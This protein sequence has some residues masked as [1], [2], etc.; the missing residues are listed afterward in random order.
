MKS[1]FSDNE[2]VLNIFDSFWCSCLKKL[3]F[4]WT[5]LSCRNIPNVVLEENL[6]TSTSPGVRKSRMNIRASGGNKAYTIWWDKFSSLIILQKVLYKGFR[7]CIHL[8]YQQR[9]SQRTD[10]N[11][12]VYLTLF[13]QHTTFVPLRIN[14]LIK[15]Y[16]ANV[17]RELQGLCREIGVQGFQI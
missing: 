14:H 13:W 15:L 2:S 10:F 7:I 11:R 6:G 4:K 1:L 5:N 3:L 12:H 17:C 9:S 16:T 8:A